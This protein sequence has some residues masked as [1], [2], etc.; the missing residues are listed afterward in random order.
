MIYPLVHELAAPDA[1]IRVPIVVMCRVLGF[2]EQ[3]YYQ[4]RGQP[5]SAREIE[6]QHLIGVLRELH[7]FGYRFLTDELQALGYRVSERRVWRLCQVAGI[8]SVITKRRGRHRKALPPA[9]DDLV[10]RDFTASTPNACWLTVI[11]E[12][13][14]AREGKP[15]LCAVKDV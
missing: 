15:Y 6:E 1:R 8:R 14:T 2:S 7:E 12:P 11:T 5:C 13:Q 9:H 4:W 3:A 10:Q